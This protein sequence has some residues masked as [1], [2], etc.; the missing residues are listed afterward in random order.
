[1]NI[2]LNPVSNEQRLKD[3]KTGRNMASVSEP[4][5]RVKKKRK[6]GDG[7][8]KVSPVS[9]SIVRVRCQNFKFEIFQEEKKNQDSYFQAF[10]Y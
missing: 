4:D 8:K 3:Y 1:M 7:G 6:E 9:A 5:T 10:T 2:L